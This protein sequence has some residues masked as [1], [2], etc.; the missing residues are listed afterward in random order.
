MPP[1]IF[2]APLQPEPDSELLDL[3]FIAEQRE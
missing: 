2:G 1:C 3:G